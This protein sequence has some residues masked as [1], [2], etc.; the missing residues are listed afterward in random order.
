MRLMRRLGFMIALLGLA[1]GLLAGTAQAEGMP[2]LDFSTPLTLS[3][4]VWGAVIF[5]ALYLLLSRWALPQAATVLKHRADTIAADL[6]AARLAM[7]KSDGAV[8]DLAAATAKARAEAQ[9]AITKASDQA[10]REAAVKAEALNARLETRLKEA[11]TQIDQAR[12]AAMASVQQVASETAATVFAR[13]TGQQP[14]PGRL[15]AAV[16][17][18]LAARAH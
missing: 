12:G 17:A 18:A 14:E 5:L 6:D 15:Q 10:Q 1:P 8:A 13:L 9:A 11:E 16:S 7:A 2:Q 3:Q 4:V